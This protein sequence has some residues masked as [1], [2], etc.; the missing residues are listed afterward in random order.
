MTVNFLERGARMH[1]R[2]TP[3]GVPIPMTEK[4]AADI[5][6][7]PMSRRIDWHESRS[8]YGYVL[9]EAL[10]AMGKE[11]RRG[12]EFEAVFWAYQMAISGRSSEEFLWERLLVI[13]IE[14]VTIACPEA[15]TR[16]TAA[17]ALYFELPEH[18]HDRHCVLVDTVCYL[19]RCPKSRHAMELLQCLQRRLHSGEARPTIPDYA[20][21]LH[22]R[23]GVEKGRGPMHYLLE[24]ATLANEVS[25]EPNYREELVRR[26]DEEVKQLLRVDKL[27]KGT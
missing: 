13:A 23:K 9:G 3:D 19:A 7:K 26:V 10:S 8:P 2:S 6:V 18:F 25:F 24:G 16:A 5:R 15:L 27:G 22:T 4:Y 12:H 21:D 1:S 17:R 11:I 14:D 20:L